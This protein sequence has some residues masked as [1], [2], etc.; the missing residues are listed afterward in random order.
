M[1]YI[2]MINID[3]V[4]K[5]NYQKV[6]TNRF[7]VDSPRFWREE[8]HPRFKD[9][10]EVQDFKGILQAV[11]GKVSFS[12][13]DTFID[14]LA[15]RFYHYFSGY[16]FAVIPGKNP[17]SPE[18]FLADFYFT[19][20]DYFNQFS[21][22]NYPLDEDD[23]NVVGNEAFT[24]K[25]DNTKLHTDEHNNSGNRNTT[26]VDF[27]EHGEMQNTNNST[28]ENADEQGETNA[29]EVNDVFLSPQNQGVSPTT[30]NTKHQGVDGVTPPGGAGFT[31]NTQVGNGGESAK[32]KSNTS[33][34]GHEAQTTTG[35]NNGMTA[36]N[37]T[38]GDFG[39]KQGTENANEKTDNYKEQLHFDRAVKLQEFYNLNSD[40]LWLQILGKLQRWILQ[41]HIATAETNY[42]DFP[43]YE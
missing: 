20:L 30:A 36:A 13:N 34:G 43:L 5:R 16:R 24:G 17:Q 12:L 3:S 7:V 6:S 38:S 42:N 26:T 21:F 22:T 33:T 23:F 40:N 1:G 19:L 35:E 11:N 41:A 31:T 18:Q 4:L 29:V 37:E 32:N 39:M 28:V 8:L 10:F 14:Q 9:I 15:Q 2:C 27:S 25:K